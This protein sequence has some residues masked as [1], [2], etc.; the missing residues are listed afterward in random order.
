[1][2]TLDLSDAFDSSFLTDVLVKRP[3]LQLSPS[4]EYEE[5]G[6]SVWGMRAVVIPQSSQ[7]TH[8][9]VNDLTTGGLELYVM[10]GVE[11]K[12]Q[13]EPA[14]FIIWCGEEYRIDLMEDYGNYG[15]GFYHV[16]CT[17]TFTQR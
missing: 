5:A 7:P 13:L 3:A 9:E 15:Q 16:V 14:D 17:K 12:M 2:A 6:F 11:P 4:G 1:M 8:S 10:C